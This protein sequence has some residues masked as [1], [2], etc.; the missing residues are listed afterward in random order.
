MSGSAIALLISPLRC[1]TISSGV[2][3]GAKKPNGE[4]GAGITQFGERG[5][6]GIGRGVDGALE[7]ARTVGKND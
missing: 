1:F 3:P 4:I 6:L 7:G 2:L 5:T